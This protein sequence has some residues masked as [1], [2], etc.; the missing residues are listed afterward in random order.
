MKKQ[1]ITFLI[2][3]FL[4]CLL[5]SSFLT[6]KV[7]ASPGW[8]NVTSPSSGATY[9]EGNT[10]YIGWS[11]SNIGDYVKIELH[12]SGSYFTTLSYNTSSIGGYTW[13]IPNGYSSNYNYQIKVTSIKYPTDYDYSGN[14]YINQKTITITSPRSGQTLY[15]GDTHIIRW[16]SQNTGNIF[17]IELYKIGSLAKIITSNYYTSGSSKSYS[18]TISS[19][20]TTSSSYSIK[21]IDTSDISIYDYSGSFAISERSL[22]I[23]SP[24]GGETWFKGETYTILWNSKNIGDYV[25]I[26]YKKEHAYYYNTIDTSAPNIGEYEWKIPSHLEIGHNYQIK[27]NSWSYSNIYDISNSFS[28]DE[29]YININSPKF[30]DKWLP[31]EIHIITWTSKNAGD[32]V[33]IWLLKN[34]VFYATIA[35]NIKNN[36][37][38]NWIFENN[39][40]ADSDYSI[41]IM[42]NDY[43]T[44]Y[45]NSVKFTIGGQSIS[46]KSPTD[47]DIWYK[48]KSY[49]IT[50]ISQNAGN[51]VNITLY[52]NGKYYYTIATNVNNTGYFYWQKI[53][54]DIQSDSAYQIKVESASYNDVYALSVGSF[55]IKETFIQQISGPIIIIAIISITSVASYFAYNKYRKKWQME[56]QEKKEFEEQKIIQNMN[57]SVSQDEYEKIWEE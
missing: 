43:S 45:D 27:I 17:R 30:D 3:F 35:S 56:K 1:I 31:N 18:W 39:Y 49:S 50:W 10:I 55:S 54:S 24:S 6:I 40:E 25:S 15:Q 34:D 33:N 37:S 11:F 57:T 4:L 41:Q 22:K 2:L 14:F 52:K 42:S 20:I 7:K 48:E 36:G 23:T 29:R 5:F 53:P 12:R 16:T 46:I 28:F 51:S 26:K 47:N 44:V 13:I 38:Y 9:Y 19:E 32:K 21:I 8:I